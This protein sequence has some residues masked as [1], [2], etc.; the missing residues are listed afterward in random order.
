MLILFPFLQPASAAGLKECK[1]I[2][3]PNERME[4][5]EAN[6]NALNSELEKVSGAANGAVKYGDK[7]QLNSVSL[8]PGVWIRERQPSLG[9]ATLT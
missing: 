3:N 2:N 5:L 9:R 6:I 1:P 8:A 7:V 4:C